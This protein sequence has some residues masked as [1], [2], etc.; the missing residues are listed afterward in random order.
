MAERGYRVSF[1]VGGVIITNIIENKII[2]TGSID[3][4]KR[5]WKFDLTKLVEVSLA[6]PVYNN[7]TLIEYQVNL[8][9]KDQKHIPDKVIKQIVELH[10]KT[11]HT[12]SAEDLC[13][14]LTNHQILNVPSEITTERIMAVFNKYPCIVCKLAKMKKLVIPRGTGV[15]PTTVGTHMSVDYIPISTVS[16]RRFT[17]FFLFVCMFCKYKMAVFTKNRK[18]SSDDFIS[19]INTVREF[20]RKYRHDIRILRLDAGTTE[21]SQ[22]VTSWCGN[23]GIQV[24]P[25]AI[26]HQHQNPVEAHVREPTSAVAATMAS[27]TMLPES[28]WCYAVESVLEMTNGT[29]MIDGISSLCHMTDS[30]VD[31]TKDLQFTFGHPVAVLANK[32]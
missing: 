4:K 26:R 5:L 30:R 12:A 7:K 29:T 27:Q 32:D 21:N 17:G 2:F 23:N 31:V 13:K 18:H 25:A 10:N 16:V 3:F 1:D 14:L 9:I 19:A 28:F 15:E 8:R 6:S 22:S 20:L 11:N 24:K